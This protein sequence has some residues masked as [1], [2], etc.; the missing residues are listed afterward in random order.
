MRQPGAGF[1]AQRRLGAL[2]PCVW[3]SPVFARLRFQTLPPRPRSRLRR[4]SLGSPHGASKGL[5]VDLTW[6]ILWSAALLISPLGWTY[7]LWWGAGPFGALT[8]HA[9]RDRPKLQP[10]IIAVGACFILPLGTVLLGQPSV[11]A[12]F[13]IG[14]IFTWALLAIWIGAVSD[15]RL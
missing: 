9:W 14:S 8:L 11:V 4:P 1:A 13:T 2:G 5:D 6:S 7:Y 15:E 12:S 3:P 10:C